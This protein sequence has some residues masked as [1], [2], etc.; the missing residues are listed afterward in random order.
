MTIGLDI[1]RDPRQRYLDKL[2]IQP[3]VEDRRRD[4]VTSE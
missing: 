1:F 4:A 3:F 2:L